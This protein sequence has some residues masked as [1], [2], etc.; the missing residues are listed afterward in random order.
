MPFVILIV[1]IVL[2][3]ASVR[4]RQD[5]LFSLLKSEFSGENSF[6]PWILALMFIGGIGYIKPLKPISNAFIVLLITVL[7]LSNGGFFSKLNQ[8]LGIKK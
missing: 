1:G 7:F 8:Q 6:L 2:V 4:D 5:L 3:V